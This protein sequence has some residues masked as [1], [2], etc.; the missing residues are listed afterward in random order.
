MDD[1]KITSVDDGQMTP[2]PSMMDP[3][4][5]PVKE[6]VIHA[7][8]MNKLDPAMYE[9]NIHKATVTWSTQDQPGT[10]LWFDELTPFG[11][12]AI[13]AHHAECYYYWVGDALYEIKIAGTNFHSGMVTVVEF[14]PHIHPSTMAG[15]R[16]YTALNWRA[17]DAKNPDLQGFRVRDVRQVAFHYIDSKHDQS[18]IRVGG[19]IG[20]F[21]DM[22]L[23][24]SSTGTQQI[25]IQVWCKPAPNF[26]MLKL[27]IPRL[28]KD[29]PSSSVQYLLDYALDFSNA[30][31]QHALASSLKFPVD[32][33]RVLEKKVSLFQYGLVNHF[34]PD[35]KPMS[36]LSNFATFD[37]STSTVYQ[38]ERTA[39]TGGG[40]VNVNVIPKM[41]FRINR[42]DSGGV[43]YFPDA[44]SSS[45]LSGWIDLNPPSKATK[46]LL[47]VK[48]SLNDSAQ[49]ATLN[50]KKDIHYM[51]NVNQTGFLSEPDPIVTPAGESLIV[52]TQKGN[53][54]LQ[55]LQM[56]NFS[57]LCARGYLKGWLPQGMCARFILRDSVEKVPVGVVKLYP[58]GYFTTR[59]SSDE[60]I[61]DIEKVA[62][63][64]DGFMAKTTVLEANPEYSKN[65]LLV[66]PFHSTYK[67]T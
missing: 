42:N 43:I 45:T 22:A 31:E 55:S 29:E 26:R 46:A 50:D 32:K 62:L 11:M 9:Q 35:A 12:N 14:P 25:N 66:L 33:M 48:I 61:Y 2:L 47:Q 54:T 57:E 17:I 44:G 65:R 39:V 40:N 27:R 60:V 38:V 30:K 18:P 16:D 4:E 24:T 56:Q 64:F 23:N 3:A 6:A 21:V 63:S 10:L 58:E 1:N 15:T 8:A 49:I 52:F 67:R 59:A 20:L 28:M 19:Y 13:V 34:T 37:P 41:P 51:V 7:G 5:P 53:A 36:A